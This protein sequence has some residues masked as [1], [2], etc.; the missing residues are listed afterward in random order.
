M[1]QHDQI[2][3]DRRRN[4]LMG[5][6]RV[7][8]ERIVYPPNKKGKENVKGLSSHVT[9]HAILSAYLPKKHLYKDH[10]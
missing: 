3:F 2:V 7:H 10:S 4:L 1:S 6:K 8:R 5:K 9:R